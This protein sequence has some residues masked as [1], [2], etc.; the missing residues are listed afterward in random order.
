ME[1]RKTRACDVLGCIGCVGRV[2]C[3]CL[4]S[5]S[6][7]RHFHAMLA[8]L[9]LYRQRDGCFHLL[10]RGT[11]QTRAGA[12]VQKASQHFQHG[13]HVG[14]GVHTGMP[15]YE[16]RVIRVRRGAVSSTAGSPVQP[17]QRAQLGCDFL[18]KLGALTCTSARF[19]PTYYTTALSN[20]VWIKQLE[21]ILPYSSKTRF[22]CTR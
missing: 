8:K 5:R 3:A 14:K 21:A 17:A 16:L 22:P 13:A 1:R 10:R 15:P 19:L 2:V 11:K 7:R 4:V 9:L 20:N 18:P 6:R 12:G